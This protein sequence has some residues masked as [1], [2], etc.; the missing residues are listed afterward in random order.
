MATR[1]LKDISLGWLTLPNA[2]PL[3]IIEAAALAGFGH[4]S[5]RMA[6][7]RTE[8]SPGFA[9]DPILCREIRACLNANDVSLLHMGG[10]WL[11]GKQPVTE[12]EQAIATSVELGTRM[13]VAIFTPERSL[14][15]VRED[16]FQL[17]RICR[18]YDVRVAVEFG[19]YLGVRN[20]DEAIRLVE[21][22]SESNAGLLIDTLHLFRSGGN[23]TLVSAVPPEKIF[24]TQLCDAPLASPEFSQLQTEARGNRFDPGFGEF[25]ISELLQALKPTATLEVEAPCLAYRNL[26][27]FERANL[28]SQAVLNLLESST[29][30]TA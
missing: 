13:S 24:L 30:L 5:L 4:V 18:K 6:A 22:C 25:A 11:D 28:A 12:F 1:H 29:V 2:S 16:L 27:H 9:S 15:E 8:Q 7:R 20:I 21:S 26:N 23:P 10:I 17:C 19:A 3:Q 14:E